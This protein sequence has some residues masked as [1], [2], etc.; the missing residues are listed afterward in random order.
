MFKNIRQN[1]KKFW[2]WFWVESGQ[3]DPPT[4]MRPP[5]PPRP[6][7]PPRPKRPEPDK[8]PQPP[9]PPR[10]KPDARLRTLPYLLWP[11]PDLLAEKARLEEE[12]QLIAMSHAIPRMDV[13]WGMADFQDKMSFYASGAVLLEYRQRY[14]EVLR[15]LKRRNA[16]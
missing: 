8:L 6:P 9:K 3:F 11:T 10:H 7:R 1:L 5:E 15:E 4:R 12:Y 2:R 14:A 13:L 16:V